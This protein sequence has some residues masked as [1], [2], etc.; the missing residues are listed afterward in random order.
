MC[1]QPQKTL[2]RTGRSG[3][4]PY[5]PRFA[6]EYEHREAEQNGSDS[7]RAPRFQPVSVHDYLDGECHARRK[8]EY[9]DGI[10]Y[11]MVGGTVAHSR[12][13]SNPTNYFIPRVLWYPHLRR[14]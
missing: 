13:A 4:L 5:L 12:I 1:R 2:H 14:F 10:I 9:V 7:M 3:V 11:A 8:H 6:D